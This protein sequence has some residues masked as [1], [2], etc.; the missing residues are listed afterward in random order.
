M[1]NIDDNLPPCFGKLSTVFPKDEESGFRK[2]PDS[3]FLCFYKTRCLKTAMESKEGLAIQE[4]VLEKAEDSKLVG[5]FERWS[6]KKQINKK[7]HFK[8][9]LS[10]DL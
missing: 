2:S 5:F 6:R 4:E 8:S 10:R 7:K 3:C 9:I 1:T